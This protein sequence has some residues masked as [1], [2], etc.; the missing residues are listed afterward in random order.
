[1]ASHW[2]RQLQTHEFPEDSLTG[3]CGKV[4]PEGI[5]GRK[6]RGLIKKIGG[7]RQRNVVGVQHQDL[8][9]GGGIQRHCL[10]DIA[11]D[12]AM[13]PVVLWQLHLGDIEQAE[14]GELALHAHQPLTCRDGV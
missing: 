4:R 14:A 7:V 2:A 5:A 10:D 1:M 11:L 12:G 8:I 9:K 13:L 3:V 6:V